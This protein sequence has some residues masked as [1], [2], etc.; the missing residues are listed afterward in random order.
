MSLLPFVAMAS[1]K[2]K[3][4]KQRKAA[5]ELAAANRRND[6]AISAAIMSTNNNAAVIENYIDVDNM[7]SNIPESDCDS[8]MNGFFAIV[9]KIQRADDIATRFIYDNPPPFTGTGI[10]SIVIGFLKRCENES[11]DNVIAEVG[12]DLSSP[13]IYCLK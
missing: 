11:F 13:N 4:G 10:L 1:S 8:I 12:G 5:K 7:L 9:A 6:A 3:R 2:K